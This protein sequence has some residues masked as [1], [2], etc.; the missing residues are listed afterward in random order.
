MIK[1]LLN[2]LE[3]KPEHIFLDPMAGSA[4]ACIEAQILGIDSI[5]IDINPFC[6]LIGK[7]KAYAT[8]ISHDSMAYL[9]SITDQIISTVVKSDNLTE[10]ENNLQE[11]IKRSDL[12]KSDTD[13]LV[14]LISLAYLDS[15]GYA[16]RRKNRTAS[17][18]F[19][20]V[21]QRYISTTNNFHIFLTNNTSSEH[22][23]QAQLSTGTVMNMD[24]NDDSIDCIIT[25]PPYSFA[26]DYVEND[27][28]QLEL[29]NIDIEKIKQSMLGLRGDKKEQ[30]MENYLIDMTIAFQEMARVLKLNSFCAVII[31]SN[32]LQTGGIKLDNEFKNIVSGSSLKYIRDII[33]PIKGLQNTLHEEHILIF[34]KA[35]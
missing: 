17:D 3:V 19:P 9:L 13:G 21:L 31:G 16:R 32:S 14:D 1:G 11:L 27:A 23:G 25:S 4:T 2:V 8:S 22:L 33:K 20:E 26:I 18:L 24:L 7:A 28:P 30:R 34:Q 29:M 5:G 10:V 6:T 15:V 12:P 35:L